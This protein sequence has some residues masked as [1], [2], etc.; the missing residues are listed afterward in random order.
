MNLFLKMIEHNVLSV[1][2]IS[3]FFVRE[4]YYKNMSVTKVNLVP[5]YAM[6]YGYSVACL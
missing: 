3:P 4:Y 6:L 1:N 2:F 5:V